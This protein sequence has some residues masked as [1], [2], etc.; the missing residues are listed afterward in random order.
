MKIKAP[1]KY[2]NKDSISPYVISIGS[3]QINEDDKDDAAS[4]CVSKKSS[5]YS[6]EARFYQIGG[7]CLFTSVVCTLALWI[8]LINVK[9]G[10]FY[11]Y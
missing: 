1:V 8:L 9:H 4:K 10:K 6:K 11:S 7:I 2:S 3:S 5:E